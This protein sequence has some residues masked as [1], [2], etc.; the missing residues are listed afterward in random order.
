M[1]IDDNVAGGMSPADARRETLLH[2]GNPAATRERVTAADASL[3]LE[4]FAQDLRYAAR[5]LRRSPGFV[6]AAILPLA[7]GIANVV[8]FAVLNA[9]LMPSRPARSPPP[10]PGRGKGAGKLGAIVS[11]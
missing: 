2:F 6:L 8:V 1:R 10:V 7:P 3:G 9:I 4:N 11:R 5:G